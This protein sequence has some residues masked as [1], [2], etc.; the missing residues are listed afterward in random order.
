[1]FSTTAL[2][3][4]VF[5]AFFEEDRLNG[6]Y[7]KSI[8]VYKKPENL[9]YCGL[10]LDN[11]AIQDFTTHQTRTYE[12]GLEN[13]QFLNVFLTTQ[14][15]YN[16][17]EN[18][19]YVTKEDFGSKAFILCYDLTTSGFTS[20]GM[21]PLLKTGSLKLRMEFSAATPKPYNCLIFS[22]SPATMCI[23]MNRNVTMSYRI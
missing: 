18:G 20:E 16:S 11:R 21:F 9:V 3:A 1:M 14:T 19:P 13:F 17:R 5:V 22:T 4:K 12:S 8:Q 10:E 2:P 7:K 6:D 15:Y 23:D